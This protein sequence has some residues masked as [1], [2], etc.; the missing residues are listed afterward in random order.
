MGDLQNIPGTDEFVIPSMER[1]LYI[2]NPVGFVAHMGVLI[3]MV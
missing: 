2:L 3:M 1:W